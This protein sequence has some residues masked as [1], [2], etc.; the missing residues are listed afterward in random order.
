MGKQALVQALH[1]AINGAHGDGVTFRAYVDAE[2]LAEDH[3]MPVIVEF[4]AEWIIND[5]RLKWEGEQMAD[6]WR[7]EMA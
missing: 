5:H 4:V 2:E 7:E 3:L 1:T 6:S